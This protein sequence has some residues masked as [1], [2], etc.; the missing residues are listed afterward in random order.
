M[1]HCIA[2]MQMIATLDWLKGKSLVNVEGKG[3]S[4]FFAFTEGGS[5]AT[6]SF[7]RLLDSERLVVSSEDHEQL[8]GLKEPVDAA[9]SVTKVVGAKK[10]TEYSCSEVCSDLILRFEN[11]I[12]LQFL[13]TSSG[14]E[15]WRAWHND[16]QVI[17][18]G[19][20][21]LAI[22]HQKINP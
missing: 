13:N 22:I 6:E 2:L 7:W 3:F 9:K 15:S 4:W 16:V 19:G 10:I 20:G 11:K 5:I 1:A 21:E 12:E 18:T 17:C 14:Y 8:F